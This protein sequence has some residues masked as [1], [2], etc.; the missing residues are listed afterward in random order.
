MVRVASVAMG[1]GM[2]SLIFLVVFCC[3]YGDSLKLNDLHYNTSGDY[4]LIQKNVALVP[5]PLGVNVYV[6]MNW[7]CTFKFR[8]IFQTPK[9]TP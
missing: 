4:N 2:I 3:D 7:K 5:V 6:W 1:S 8:D 9:A